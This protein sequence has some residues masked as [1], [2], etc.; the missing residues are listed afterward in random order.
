MAKCKYCGENISRL[1][2]EICPFC[3]GKK[4]LDGTDT[5]TQDITQFLDESGKAK[6]VRH[7]SKVV[8]AI[9]A[10]FVGFLGGHSFYLKKI[11]NGFI[12]LLIS[13]FLIAGIGSIIYF[14][15][16]KSVF[17]YLIPY[18][19]LEALMIVV[20]ISYLVRHDV[21]DGNGEFLE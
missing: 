14:A 7:C 6:K 17:A 21:T 10:I 3:G 19:V 8:A 2:K 5:S 1:D 16:F 9:L 13:I 18:F 15:G 4:P 12:I 11:K 20:G